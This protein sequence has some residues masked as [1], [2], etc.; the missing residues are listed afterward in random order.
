[1]AQVYQL[2]FDD[3]TLAK[4]YLKNYV[5]S[6]DNQK[7]KPNVAVVNGL[8]AR[9]YLLTGQWEEAAK[10]AEAARARYTLMTTTAE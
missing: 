6:G 1:M 4:D 2:I 8:L 3:L 7:F 10:A 9:A 5:R